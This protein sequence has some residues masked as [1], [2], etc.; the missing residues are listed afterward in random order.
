M[1]SF[2]PQKLIQISRTILLIAKRALLS[3]SPDL[4]SLLLLVG[5]VLWFN[6]QMIWD[7][8]IPLFRDLGPYFYPMR[9]S[10]AESFKAGELPLWDR[11][12][13]MG[14]PLLADFQSGAFYP[15][16]LFYAVFGFFAAIRATFLFHYLVAATGGYM[17]CRRWDYPPYLAL[18]GAILFALGG[19]IVSLS[20]LL[21]HFQ[22]AVWL[23]WVIF[24][25][26]RA[27]RSQS[28]GD[29]LLFTLASLLQ[30][31]A[32]SP[33]LYAMS[34]GLVFLD[35]LRMK[36]A[37]GNFTYGRALCLFVAAHLLVAGL[38][39]IQVLPTLELLTESRRQLLPYVEASAWSFRPLSLLNLFFP[40]KEVDLARFTLPRLFFIR[41]LPLFVSHYL[42][43]ISL[44]GISL[45][46]YHGSRR[47]KV[48]ILALIAATLVAAMGR[49]TPLYF[50]LFQHLP[51]LGLFRFPEKFFFLTHALLLFAALRGLFRFLEF[52][53]ATGENSFLILPSICLLF[54]A[55]YL[56]LRFNTESLAQFIVWTTG[57]SPDSTATRGS[58]AL[59]NL[60]RQIGLA[61]GTLLLFFCAKRNL[62]EG[63]L[64]KALLAALVL[65]DL[66]SAHRPYQFLLEPNLAYK[67][68]KIIASPDPQPHRLF[69]FPAPP[70]IHPSIYVVPKE[71]PLAQF[72]S[73]VFDNLLPNTGVLHGFDYMQEID[74]LGRWPYNAFLDFAQG[75]PR[76]K[77]YPLLGVLNVKYLNSF[78]ALPEGEITLIRHFPEYPSW[79]YRVNRTVPRAYI[80]PGATVERDPAKVLSRLSSP[81]FDPLKEVILERP[82]PVAA[83]RNFRS[84]AEITRYTNHHL[85]IQASLDSMGVLVLADS[86]YPGW[87][88]SVDGEKKEILRAN[89][90]FRGVA[91]SPGEHLVEFRYRPRSFR[92]GLIISMATLCGVVIGSVVIL[93]A[94][95]KRSPSP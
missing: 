19:A 75:L 68:S 46:L 77:L 81:E 82:L 60:E 61:F 66:E 55:L 78:Q 71:P 2:L 67:D 92:I 95:R 31:L 29:F 51:F 13:A 33:E 42:G 9:F 74:A 36:L 38:A 22:T 25:W 24:F 15:P 59:V 14:F 89:L 23:P 1:A 91:L 3:H 11:H 53:H 93:A 27:L 20:N 64:F 50:F 34:V 52:E 6:H 47:E 12:V 72:N 57:A 8:K 84:R 73:L 54:V 17:L 87:E 63:P 35:G 79:L 40:D 48:I 49:H 16:H 45:W 41:H 5:I 65:I 69:Y 7:G 85:A 88:V 39:M 86:F 18:I 83:N 58:A 80:V 28:W 21:N 90:F 94:R 56:F 4:S 70:D 44:V 10:L 37:E 32:G 30:F 43:W 76:P 62:L 26:E